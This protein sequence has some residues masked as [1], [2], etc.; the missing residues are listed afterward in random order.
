MHPTPFSR[1]AFMQ[2]ACVTA[3]ALPFL[4]AA[5]Q[6]PAGNAPD[7]DWFF[8]WRE[9]AP[10]VWIALGSGGN[11]MVV[12]GDGGT[13][14]VDCKNAPYGEALKRESA[15]RAAPM[16]QVVNT[17][18]HGDH[19]GGNHAFTGI[20]I[21]AHDK[22]TDRVLAQMNRYLSQMKEAVAQLD[23]RTG[24]A[25]DKVRDEAK[26]FYLRASEV[27]PQD[28][29]PRTTFSQDRELD[30]GGVT[31]NLVHFG[32]GHTDNDIVV[33]LPAS[34]ILHTGD[35]LFH[36]RHPFVDR[37]GGGNTRAWQQ[38]LGKAAAMCNDK[39][40]VIPG[41]G[42]PTDA[43]GLRAQVAYFDTMRGIVAKA[44]AEGRSR[45]DVAEMDPGVYAD[46]PAGT[47]TI[48]LGALFDEL[49]EP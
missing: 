40:V 26:A 27:K 16:T 18:H 20:D 41:H 22:A 13:L 31:V 14:L 23:G 33:F 11:S 10:G 48:V 1:R 5:A 28:F 43:T 24:P 7:P 39:T 46:Y 44:K 36:K 15:A 3:A 42:E 25:A 9:V 21:L 29:A 49:A 47:R 32:P 4:P 2:A 19:T 37:N 38:A 45:K 6:Q 30:I 12:K 34:N 17:H 35:L 8:D